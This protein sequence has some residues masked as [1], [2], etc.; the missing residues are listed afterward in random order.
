MAAEPKPKAKRLGR[1]LSAL[2]GEVEGVGSYSGEE[3][4]APPIT[5]ASTIAIRDIRPNPQ[6]PRRYFGETE[7]TEL[8]E[9]IRAKGVLQA[10]LVRPDPKETGKYQ[11]IAGERRWRAAKQAGLTEIPAMIRNLDELELLEIGIIENVQRTDLNPIEEAEAYGALMKRF[12][13]T[14]EGLAESVGK[15]RAHIANTIRLLN[16]SETARNHLREGR[17]TAGHARA[18][19]GAPDPDAVI[20]MTVQ[21][22]LSV[23]D[24]E[25]LVKRAKDDGSLDAIARKVGTS[26]KD[27]DT[28]ALEADLSR[29]LGLDVDIRHKATGGELRIKYRDLEQL[30]DLCRKLTAK[31]SS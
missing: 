1:G 21:K 9:S 28:E 13:R 10:I 15:S 11:I 17:I 30:D 3:G 18:A 20:A 12:G 8:A 27:V 14:Q 26:E 31:R 24:V 23:R 16:L 25:G 2:I 5:D 6:Q 19:L 29:A 4:E 7:L 22:N